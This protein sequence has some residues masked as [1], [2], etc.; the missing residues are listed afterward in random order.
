MRV[1]FFALV[2][3]FIALVLTIYPLTGAWIWYR[4]HLLLLVVIYWALNHGHQV[5]VLYAYTIGLWLDISTESLL[6][7]NAFTFA[8]VAYLTLKV[9]QRLRL[10]PLWQQ[11]FVIMLFVGVY[12][13]LMLWIE[14][15]TQ[16]VT[17]TLVYWMP[18]LTTS[19]AWPLVKTFLNTYT[20]RL[21]VE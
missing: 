12:Q 9:H 18:L 13:L 17:Y 19:L 16:G 8:L 6:G 15:I 2:T 1:F 20:K 14:A 4:P 21:R 7:Q 5:G 10:F 3:A 11:A